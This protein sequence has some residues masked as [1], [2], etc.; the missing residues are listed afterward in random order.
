MQ[1]DSDSKLAKKLIPSSQVRTHEASASAISL[2]DREVKI[3]IVHSVAPLV[4][5]CL[6]QRVSESD[7]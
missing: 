4:Q 1:A 6:A 3:K 5:V 2:L 7:K